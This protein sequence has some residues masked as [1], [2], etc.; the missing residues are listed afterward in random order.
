[1]LGPSR[2]Y[3]V[4]A[5]KAVGRLAKLLRSS[6]QQRGISQRQLA[7]SVGINSSLVSRLE[8]GQNARLLTW[9]ALFEGMDY[10]LLFDVTELSEEAQ[11]FMDAEAERRHERQ[12]G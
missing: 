11:D 3:V 6:R 7:D 1:M 12:F 2:M 8:K 5:E 9:A 4:E 10:R